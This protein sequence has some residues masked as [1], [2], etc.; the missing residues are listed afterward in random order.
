MVGQYFL[1]KRFGRGF[2]QPSESNGKVARL[3]GRGA[4][5]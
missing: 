1:E 3:L 2:G 4:A 5:H